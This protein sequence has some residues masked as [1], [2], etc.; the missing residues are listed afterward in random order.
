[1]KVNSVVKTPQ[2]TIQFKGELS[3]D[4]ADAV[5]AAGL[6]YY[7]SVGMLAVSPPPPEEDDGFEVEGNDTLN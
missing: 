2:G 4:T 5:V 6:M 3:Q 7:I 1:M